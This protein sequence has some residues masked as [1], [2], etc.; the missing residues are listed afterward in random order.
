VPTTDR[1]QGRG[2]MGSGVI[3]LKRIRAAVEGAGYDGPIE[4]EVINRE[5]WDRPG[6]EIVA[7]ACESFLRAA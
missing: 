2:M 6:D 5:A 4:V 3:D 7:D 1:L